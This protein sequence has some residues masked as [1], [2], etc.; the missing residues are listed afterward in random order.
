MAI[1]FQQSE[2]K[3]AKFPWTTVLLVILLLLSGA[4]AWFLIFKN[5]QQEEAQNSAAM[6]KSWKK[7]EVNFN[8]LT[9]QVFTNLQSFQ[10][11]PDFNGKIGRENPFK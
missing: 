4:A 6:S 9:D 8:L 1:N 2:I 3:K 10:K 11:V 7:I 5:S